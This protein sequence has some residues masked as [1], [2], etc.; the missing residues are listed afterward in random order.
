VV[1]R[2]LQSIK[3]VGGVTRQGG[4]D[5]EIRIALDPKKLLALGVTAADVNKQVRATNVDLSG[6]RGEIASQEQAIRTLAGSRT[7]DALRALPIALPGGRKVRLDDLATVTDDAVEARTFARLNGQPVVAFAISRAKGASDATVAD[8]VETRL[9]KLHTAHP[10]VTLTKVDT[11][12]DNTIGNFRSA[13]ETLIEGAVL[14][15]IVVFLFLRDIRATIVSAIALPLSAI[16]TFWAMS[17]LGFSLNLV[18]LLAITLVTGILVDDAIVEVENIVRHMRMGKSAY[19]ASLEAA[20]EI[21]LAVI[22]I[23]MTIVAV[24][25]PVSFMGGI[26]GQ[27]FRQFGLTVSV[28]VLFSL[29]VARLITPVVAAYFMRSHETPS[30]DEGPLLRAY[31]RMVSWSLRHRWITLAAGL[32]LFVASIA[33]TKLLPS[34]FIPPEDIARTLLAVELPP[35]SRLTDTDAVTRRISDRIKAMPEVRSVM[36]LGGQILGG[37]SEV[38]KAT[39]VVNLVHKSERDISQKDVE[40]EIAGKIG[41]VPDVRFWFLRDN[42]QRDLQLIVAG[43]DMKAINET[44]NQIASEMARLPMLKNPIST[45][46]LDRPELQIAP[47]AQIAADLGVSTESLSETIRVATLGDIDANLAKFDAGNRLIPIRVELIQDAR[48]DVDLL[49]ALR[50]ATAAGGAIPLAAIAQFDMG[51]GPTAINRYDRTRRVTIEADLTGDGALGEATAAIY[52]LPAAKNLP[53]GVTLREFG[54]VEVMQDVFSSFGAAM[55]A[56]LM[57]VFGVLILLFGSFGQPVTILF[58]LPLSIGGAIIALLLTGRPIS[59]PVVIGILMLMGIVTK[60]AIMLVD[61][62]LEEMRHGK[63]RIDALIEAGRKR[64][65]PI[66]MTTIAMVAGMFPSALAFGDG[67]AFRSPM[68]IAV[69]GGLVVSTG[70]SLIFVPAVFTLL[71]DLG[72]LMWRVFSLLINPSEDRAASAA[73]AATQAELAQ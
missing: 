23:S 4:V 22:A 69:I 36:V 47:R 62:A 11:Q 15:V 44:A 13:M 59:M 70:L 27:Y 31:T 39:L 56:G 2:E 40:V 34:G 42:G 48:S 37:A 50:V 28:A 32:A 63:S 35:G 33:S 17:A 19:R 65:R 61:M 55:G 3:G 8:L 38:R 16:P 18:T 5:R 58:S 10:E 24:F 46:E 9:A 57:M 20:D 14:A 1:A 6:G 64:A 60:N 51:R 72:R 12:V 25:A 43:S 29:L 66:V 67:G 73:E 54:D 52:A 53:Q 49:K 41:D 21:G 71:D 68:A 7:V 45:A 30:Q 26:A